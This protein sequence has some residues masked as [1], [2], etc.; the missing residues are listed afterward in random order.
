LATFSFWLILATVLSGVTIAAGAYPAFVLSSVRPVQAVRT[1]KTRSGGRFVPCLLVAMQFGSASFLLIA[2][3][4]MY[5]QNRQLTQATFTNSSNTLLSISNNVGVAGVD[6]ELLRSELQRL[7]QVQAITAAELSPWAIFG[8]QESVARS[9]DVNAQKVPIM[10]NRVHHDFFSTMGISLLAGRVFDREHATDNALLSGAQSSSGPINVVIDRAFAEQQGWLQPSE[11]LGKTFY[12]FDADSPNS[13]PTLRIVIGVVE[14]RVLTV[15]SPFG[16]TATMY[17]LNP[18]A[19][20]S[21]I[22]R[23]STTDVA[24]TLK[25]IESVWNR[26]APSVALKMRFADELLNDSS[27][28]IDLVAAAFSGIAT[29]A[30]LVSVLGLIGMSMSVIGRRQHEI[31][32]RKTLGA[33]VRSIVQLLLTDFS[34]PVI[35][36]NI[37]VW[38]LAFITMQFYLSVFTQRTSLSITPFI[39]SLVLTVLIAWIAVAAQTTRAA[40]M[41]PATVLRNE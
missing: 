30:L 6:F 10:S 38:P 12:A 39:A 35:V 4:V 7:P 36:A 5:A 22:I 34:K 31:G 1:A 2:M 9:R 40:R 23:I 19:A 21:P 3:I 16:A 17:L 8:R 27:R 29:L 28:M 37:I 26:L 14:T 33:S 32:V 25:E 41:N 24:A 20:A 18:A 11:A 13:P 15:M